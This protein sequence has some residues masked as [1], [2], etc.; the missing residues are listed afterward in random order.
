MKYLVNIDFV[1]WCLRGRPSSAHWASYVNSHSD[2]MEL[3]RA[4]SVM[5]RLRIS[6][7]KMS[8]QE[9]E[10]L[11]NSIVAD[12]RASTTFRWAKVKTLHRV[13]M[14]VAACVLV[15]VMVS[16]SVNIFGTNGCSV[17]DVSHL[18]E[19]SELSMPEHIRVISGDEVMDY[20]SLIVTH[21][22][23]TQDV[24]TVNEQPLAQASQ[25][26][27]NVLIPSNHR[28]IITLNDN[29]KVWLNGNTK[30]RIGEFTSC[31][32]S[33]EIDGEAY[34]EV[35]H[36]PQAPFMVYSRTLT[37]TVK[38]T[39]FN[40]LSTSDVSATHYVVLVEGSVE[41]DM[42][43]LG[44]TVTLAPSQIISYNNDCYMTTQ[45]D[46][47]R[48]IAWHDG[49]LSI[50]SDSIADVAAKLAEYYGVEVICDSKVSELSCSGR[51]VLFD[52]INQ[53]LNVLESIIPIR[54]AWN[55]GKLYISLE[56]K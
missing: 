39:S 21:I 13:A 43:A 8:E 26:N 30:L 17:Q 51:L 56:T 12:N 2:D 28:A 50:N 42:P 32:R 31:S 37:T 55:G 1:L 3:K 25:H 27:L 9:R 49:S 15:A 29:T 53:T 5:S 11:Y 40:I 6:K 46:V 41:V 34:F 38:G 20:K 10:S 47:N 16:V 35:A 18:S 19:L 7:P 22:D 48:Y 4:L 23:C 45:T 44:E 36:N 14:G 54:Y 24:V 33:V 52:D